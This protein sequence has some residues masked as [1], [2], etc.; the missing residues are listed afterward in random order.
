[1]KRINT[2]IIIYHRGSF[3]NEPVRMSG[4][5]EYTPCLLSALLMFSVTGPDNKSPC[6][7]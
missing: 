4:I 3:T 7:A 2:I 6:A 5:K 1:M